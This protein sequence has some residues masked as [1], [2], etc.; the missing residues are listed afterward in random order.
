MCTKTDEDTKNAPP[1]VCSAGLEYY[2]RALTQESVSG[3]APTCLIALGLLRPVAGADAALAPVPP[4]IAAAALARPIESAILDQQQ[5]LE[6]IRATVAQADQV[7]REVQRESDVPI[8]LILG[9]EAISTALEQAVQSCRDELLTA[10]PGGG[11]APELLAEALPRDLAL[12][13]RGVRQRTL[14][15]HTVL[16]HGPTL[17]YI[18]QVSA[19]GAELRTLDEVF[20]RM[21][22]CD[23]TSA[24]IPAHQ[25]ERHAAA[26]VIEHPGIIEFLVKVFE[27]AWMRAKPVVYHPAY[28]RPQL[29]TNETRR[30]VLRHM[31]GG[32]TDEAIATRLGISSRTVAT[33]I[34]KTAELLGSRSRAQLAY[35][36]ARS[37]LLEEP[38]DEREPSP[39]ASVRTPA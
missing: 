27:H 38:Q 33:H 9:Q 2:R 37:G 8:R 22:I 16:T 32:Y 15:Q 18:E 14:Y 36:V 28:Q 6:A 3:E 20:D 23:R 1:E 11:R 30:A 34:K 17:A 7:Y 5:A 29:L 31:V 35:L 24:F 39:G 13:R 4:D 10:Q 26:L 21:I 25:H 19:G 12:T